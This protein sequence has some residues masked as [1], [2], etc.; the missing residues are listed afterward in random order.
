MKYIEVQNSSDAEKIKLAYCDNGSGKPI[1]LIH[2]WPLSKEMWEYQEEPLVD[3]GFRVITYDRRGFGQ[4]DKPWNG[5]D[6][7]TLTADLKA[8]LEQLDLQDV[9]LVGFSMGGGEVARYFKNY[10]G[11]RISK[12]VLISSILPYMPKTDNNEEGVPT[13]MFQEMMDNINADRVGFLDTFGNQFF[14][15]NMLNHPVSAPLLDYYR[16]LCAVASPRATR[17][18]LEAFAYTDFRDDTP[19]INVP[20]LIIHGNSDK[21]VPIEV[22]ADKASE[23]IPENEYLVYDAA[24]HGLFYTEKDKLNADLIQFITND[25]LTTGTPAYATEEAA[26]GTIY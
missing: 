3:A 22:S 11:E 14:G 13:E 4:S 19:L 23:L 1:V 21:T 6:Y 20:T 12:V 2:G 8:V 26:T 25:T 10:G 5:Y 17:E 9:T 15:I 7:N 16:M 24:P 18:C